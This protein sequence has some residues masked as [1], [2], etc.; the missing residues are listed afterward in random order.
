[1][2]STDAVEMLAMTFHSLYT[3]PAKGGASAQEN[4]FDRLHGYGLGGGYTPGG[5]G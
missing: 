2:K 5:G 1:M 3:D 4:V